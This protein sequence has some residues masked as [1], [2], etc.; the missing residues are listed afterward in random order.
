MKDEITE[1]RTNKIQL[2]G[3]DK[4][5]IKDAKLWLQQLRTTELTTKEG[6]VSFELN[7]AIQE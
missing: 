1:A 6:A 2:A 7:P 3:I 5:D 4:A